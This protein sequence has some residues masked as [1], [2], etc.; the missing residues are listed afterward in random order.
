MNLKNYAVALLATVILLSCTENKKEESLPAKPQD[1][2]SVQT[3][4]KGK[5]YTTQKIG[6]YDIIIV[7]GERDVKWIDV[8]K[9]QTQLAKNPDDNFTK[10]ELE[11]IEEELKFG[12]QF[13]N[14]TA[15]TVFVRDT[16]FAATYV[17]NDV[18]GQYDEVK[19]GI[20][21]RLTYTDPSFSFGGG[22]PMEMTVTYVVIGADDKRLLVQT[23][24]AIDRK[25]LISLLKAE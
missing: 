13:V 25:P 5:K 20:K 6:F 18:V 24:R 9:K 17:V 21:I 22:E 11:P 7:D 2:N 8:A 15:A 19:E 1:V 16:S 3:L 12:V 4:I 14:D 23:P 10:M